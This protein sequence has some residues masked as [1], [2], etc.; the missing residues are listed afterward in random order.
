M[1][2]QV[3]TLAVPMTGIVYRITYNFLMNLIGDQ[4]EGDIR[5][6]QHNNNITIMS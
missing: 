1:Q 4:Y 2:C 5:L 6:K 3:S